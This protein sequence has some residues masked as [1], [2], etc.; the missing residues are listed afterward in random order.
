[1]PCGRHRRHSPQA[2]RFPSRDPVPDTRHRGSRAPSPCPRYPSRRRGAHARSRRRSHRR[3]G[4]CRSRQQVT[5][6]GEIAQNANHPRRGRPAADREIADRIAARSGAT[7]V[8]VVRIEHACVGRIDVPASASSIRTHHARPLLAG[9]HE[10]PGEH[11][12]IDC[13]Q[14]FA[15]APS[16]HASGAGQALVS[17]APSGLVRSPRESRS[18]PANNHAA[19]CTRCD[20]GETDDEARALVRACA[21]RPSPQGSGN[22]RATHTLRSRRR[23][24][25]SAELTPQINARAGSEALR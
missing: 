11:L 23:P 5:P 13:S 19:R 15:R 3:I 2:P 20:D 14:R 22:R 10:E 4:R 1:M 9:R 21:E 8:D 6:A 18:S 17:R 25:P 12:R 16:K 24:A 7:R